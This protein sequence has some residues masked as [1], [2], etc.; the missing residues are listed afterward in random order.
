MKSTELE[1]AFKSRLSLQTD[2]LDQLSIY[3]TKR[4]NMF[5]FAERT[6]AFIE[7]AQKNAKA[8]KAFEA[9][10]S[11]NAAK[12]DSPASY[13][14]KNQR[15]L[16]DKLSKPPFGP[17]TMGARWPQILS[18]LAAVDKLVSVRQ[19]LRVLEIGC[20]TG[21]AYDW[22][23]S[24]YSLHYTGIDFSSAAIQVAN[25]LTKPGSDG[26]FQVA[27]ALTY[28]SL[29]KF[30]MIFSIAGLPRS[31]DAKLVDRFASFLGRQG[32]LYIQVSGPPG[33]ASK[34]EGKPEAVQLVFEDSTGGLEFAGGGYC[35]TSNYVFTTKDISIAPQIYH[36]DESWSDFATCMNSDSIH[37]RERNFGYFNSNGRPRAAWPFEPKK[38]ES[39]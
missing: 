12:K 31:L 36:A 1:N 6:D 26:V 5:C 4:W 17:W 25:R 3:L 34:W 39:V 28:E 9:I 2:S 38:W 27:D 22:L 16:Y 18:S 21:F 13:S 24:K 10:L 30:D 29:E 8:L 15:G 32:I 14:P 11:E 23:R 33:P 20:G 19:P 7:F 37:E 35:H